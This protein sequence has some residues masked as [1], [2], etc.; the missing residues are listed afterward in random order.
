L[1]I[2]LNV[3]DQKKIEGTHLIQSWVLP[4]VAA[5]SGEWR[6][7]LTGVSTRR[8]GVRRPDDEAIRQWTDQVQHRTWAMRALTPM[9]RS[10]PSF[11][12]M[13][14]THRW[15]YILFLISIHSIKCTSRIKSWAPQILG[16]C[17]DGTGCTSARPGLAVELVI[18]KLQKFFVSGVKSYF[19]VCLIVFF[20]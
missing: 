8:D 11:F 14:C 6:L 1:P 12:F 7:R 2:G 19:L 13:L 17:A 9:A 4:C 20:V 5:L 16:P 15:A 18:V 3:A 10:S